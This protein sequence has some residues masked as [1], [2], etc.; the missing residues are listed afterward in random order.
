MD[1]KKFYLGRIQS[2]FDAR[3]YNLG[4]FIPRGI[5]GISLITSRNW[6]FPNDPLNQEASYHCVGFSMANFGINLPINT[7]YTNRDGHAFY[8]M[9]KELDGQPRQENGSYV[10]TAA[11]VLRNLRRINYYA[12]AAYMSNIKYWLLNRG[13]MIVGT[14]WTENMFYPSKDNKI[15]PTGEVIGGHAYLLNEWTK[16]GFIGIQNSWGSI[17]GNNGKSYISAEN[18]EKLF[19]Q[20]GEAMASVELPM[21]W[22]RR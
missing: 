8:Y 20:G 22:P 16:D 7:C 13:P 3:D 10:R 9:C 18:F 14:S 19:R 21:G 11:K 4:A 12:F 6:E 17:W 15:E 5:R 2:P 1:N